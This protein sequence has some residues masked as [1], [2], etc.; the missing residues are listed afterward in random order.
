LR[1]DWRLRIEDILAAIG[2]IERYTTDL[3]F[4]AFAQ[5]DL[6]VDAVVRN[7]TVI[8]EAARYIPRALIAQYPEIPWAKMAGFR[9]VVVHEYFGVD[10]AILW[11]TARDD[12]PPLR[13]LLERILDISTYG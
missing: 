10:L 3:D 8:G 13:P 9:N 5:D 11:E 2:R 1:R 6:V 4:T 7:I 12:L